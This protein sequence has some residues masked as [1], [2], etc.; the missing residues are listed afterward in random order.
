MSYSPIHGSPAEET[1]AGVLATVLDTTSQ[2][3][4]ARRLVCLREIAVAVAGGRGRRA[5]CGAAAAALDRFRDDLPFGVILLHEPR[6]R[7]ALRPMGT[8]GLADERVALGSL[9]VLDDEPP[10]DL[11]G[12]LA[13]GQ[14]GVVDHLP[15]SFP[16]RVDESPP[17]GSLVILPLTQDAE[18]RPIGLVLAGI[19]SRLVLDPEYLDFVDLVAGQI[20]AAVT[21]ARTDEAQRAKAADALYRAWHDPLTGLLNRPALL[22]RLDRGLRRAGRDQ[23]IIGVLFLDLDGFKSVNDTLG[24]QAGDDLLRTVATRLSGVVRPGDVVGRLAGDEFVVLCEGADGPEDLLTVGKRVL[25]ALDEPIELG[26]TVQLGGSVG[27]AWS[28]PELADAEELLNAAD[29]AMYAAKKSGSGRCVAYDERIRAALA[30][31]LQE[32]TELRRAVNSDELQL[33]VAPI[34]SRDSAVVGFEAIPCWRHPDLGSVGPEGI[35]P[36]ARDARLTGD[37]DRWVVENIARTT[38]TA[39]GAQLWVRMSEPGATDS[40]LRRALIDLVPALRAAGT[41][42]LTVLLPDQLVQRDHR[43]ADMI[44][45]ELDTAGVTVGV[46]FTD[47]DPVGTATDDIMPSK[48]RIVRLGA[49]HVHGVDRSGVS[50][51]I[52]AGTVRFAHL[53]DLRVAVRSVDTPQ[54]LATV[55][56]LH[57]DLIQGAA[58]GTATPVQD[59]GQR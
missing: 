31:K 51:A 57:C 58:V 20:A 28:G 2:V 46:D 21:R 17:A 59:N 41:P 22:D 43:L 52:L 11:A 16:V 56:A 23:R 30:A 37:I 6:M 7:P 19:S 25:T 3:L 36:V 8:W 15:G 5:V 45:A 10:N 29:M 12:V 33:R 26:R 9:G 24:H 44:A 18:G 38:P 14:M 50:R 27:I 34:E 42:V 53:L 54:E 49:R 48:I 55:R 13:S 39:H 4:A 40:R 47:T 1:A 32:T 35:E